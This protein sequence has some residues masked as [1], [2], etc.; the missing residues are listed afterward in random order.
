MGIINFNN[1]QNLIQKEVRKFATAEIESLSPEL[2]KKCMFP[3][4][5]VQ[6]LSEL[7]LLSLIVPENYGGSNLNTTSLCIVIE[8]LSKVCASLAAVVVVNNCLF[9]YPIVKYGQQSHKDFFLTK[10]SDGALG[11][12]VIEPDI[13]SVREALHVRT[14]NGDC[15]I[16]GKREFVLN[17][18]SARFCLLPVALPNGKGLYVFSKDT[19]GITVAHQR[20]LGLK[21]A[22]IVCF[23]FKD[24]LLSHGEC[25]VP[26]ESGKR[27]LEE[28][29]DY[30][31]I[32]F[33]AVSLG[34]AEAAFEA[35]LSYSKQRKQFGRPICEFHLVQ[36]MLTEMKLMI[37]AARLLVYDAAA[38]CDT[39]NLCSVTSK[40]AR[41]YTGNAAVFSGLHAIQIHGGYGYTKDYPVERYLRDAKVLQVLNNTPHDLKSEIAKELLV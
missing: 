40:N 18:E 19:K 21:S 3:T 12:Y 7:G 2:D 8:E 6:K 34:I 36:E 10:L 17:G 35:A 25:L 23:E 15:S 28:I 11:G 9:A 1:E 41:L 4:E 24:F 22:G 27:I 31:H 29:R 39:G 33:S 14:V 16:S 13:N 26:E 38:K 20:T 30:S 5:I 37:E 32:G